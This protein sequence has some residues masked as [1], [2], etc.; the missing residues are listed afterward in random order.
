MQAEMTRYYVTGLVE[1]K[2][3]RALNA[4]TDSRKKLFLGKYDNS[5]FGGVSVLVSRVQS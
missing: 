1:T 2:K 5:E 3:R 4:V